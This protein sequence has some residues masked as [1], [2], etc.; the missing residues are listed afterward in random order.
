MSDSF[1]LDRAAE[2]LASAWRA[3]AQPAGLR[4]DVRPRSLAEGY[5]VQDRLIAL[6]GHAV[7]GWKIGLAGRNFYRGAGL[8]RPI[9]GRILAPRR[10]VSGED[11]IVPRDASV[12][13]ELEIALVLA[14]DAGPV[15]TPDLIESA[16]IGFEIV[17][18]RLPDRQRIGVPATIA[19]N[20]VSHA[21]VLGQTVDLD[22]IGDIAAH[23]GVTVDGHLRARGLRGDDLPDTLAVLGHLIAH[24][25]ERGQVRRCSGVV[26][27]G[28]L[29]QPFDVAA[30]CELAVT[31]TGSALRCRLV[32]AP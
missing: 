4:A 2:G 10:H 15:V 18:S 6:L 31:G 17:S 30:P 16:H 13:I 5:D 14:C 12:T 23:A 24:L 21:V 11:V 22:A 32:P 20:C 7:V 8:S 9:F 1:D 27:T 3:G 25:R 29:T 28:T 26:F 19:D